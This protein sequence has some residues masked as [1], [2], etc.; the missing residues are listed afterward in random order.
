MTTEEKKGHFVQGRFVIDEEPE[1]KPEE[2]TQQEQ[3]TIE[4]L[5]KQTSKNAELTVESV[6][7]LGKKLFMTPEGREHIESKTR[8]IGFELQKAINEIADAAKK[9]VEKK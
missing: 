8:Q 1:Q 6:V 7:I 9:I 3:P 5:I 2:K 4:Q